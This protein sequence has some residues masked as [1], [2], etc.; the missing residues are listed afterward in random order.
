MGLLRAKI[1]RTLCITFAA[2]GV[3][4]GCAINMPV[5]IK[6]PLTSNQP[7]AKSGELQPITLSFKDAQ[8]I[9]LRQQ[10][11]LGRIPMQLLYQGKPFEPVPWLARHTVNELKSRGLPVSLAADGAPG[12]E[13][14]IKRVYIENH[15]VSGFSPF[16]TFTFLRADVMTPDGPRRVTAYVKRGKVP[17]WSFDEVI[18]PTYNEPLDVASKELAAKINRLLFGQRI[19]DAQVQRLVA[20]IQGHGQGTRETYLDVYQLGFGNNPAAIPELVR[21]TDH[22]EEY[23]RL[24]ALS[25]LG[26]LGAVDRFDFL[27]ARYRQSGGLWQERTMALK[28]IGDLGTAQAYRF[29]TAEL[30]ALKG[31]T[32]LDS[33]WTRAMLALYLDDP[34]PPVSANAPAAKPGANP[35]NPVPAPQNAATPP[36]ALGAATGDVRPAGAKRGVERMLV[37]DE[38]AAHV[39]KLLAFEA[40]T[41]SKSLRLE[42]YGQRINVQDLGSGARASGTYQVKAPDNLVCTN[43][44]SNQRWFDYFQNCFQIFEQPDGGF[45]WRVPNVDFGF[46]YRLS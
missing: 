16:V 23:V 19:D 41:R 25:S 24:A 21:L 6:D 37:G 36:E 26:I 7:Y 42:F 27:A 12:T 32:D 38:F 8:S 40:K 13:V 3:L 4:S 31:R 9:S 43:V 11:L 34:T 22:N 18:D 28:A 35:L 1:W 45:I 17:V 29:L 30:E 44:R 46:S 15:R 39:R 2:A 14:Q 20:R 33:V 5:P 10:L